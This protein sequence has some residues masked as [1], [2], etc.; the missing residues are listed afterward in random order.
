MR[1][2]ELTLSAIW[3][4]RRGKDALPFTHYHLW[5]GRELSLESQDGRAGL[6]PHLL[7]HMRKQPLL[8]FWAVLELILLLGDAGEPAL[9]EYEQQS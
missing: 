1:T 8:P 9:R 5:Q 7:Q 2:R 3:W 6:D 4:H